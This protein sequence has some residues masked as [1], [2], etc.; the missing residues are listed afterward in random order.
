MSLRTNSP[1]N[2][3]TELIRECPPGKGSYVTANNEW[4]E[5]SMWRKTEKKT[6]NFLTSV[7]NLMKET[8][9]KY[10][11]KVRKLETTIKI[12]K[13]MEIYNI[14]HGS[15]DAR[16]SEIIHY[17][18]ILKSKVSWRVKFNEGINSLLHSAYKF[19]WYSVCEV[20]E[21]QERFIK[22]KHEFIRAFCYHNRD[23][24]TRTK[25][26]QNQGEFKLVLHN[27][28]CK[29]EKGYC[30]ICKN[31]TR[32]FCNTCGKFLCSKTICEIKHANPHVTIDSF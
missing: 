5:V 6:C 8:E 23:K 12:P 28:V 9:R 21:K 25:N 3:W 2:L 19:F 22:D 31:R 16:R 26:F 14:Y 13:V 30:C 27:T 4:C 24:S 7:P 20:L 17:Q 10:Y 11:D 1:S 29:D 18:N 32:R 15:T